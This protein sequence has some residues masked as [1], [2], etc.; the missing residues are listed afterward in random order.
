[1]AFSTFL[2][3]LVTFL[4][5]SY[6]FMTLRLHFKGNF[7][8]LFL[9]A[10]DFPLLSWFGSLHDATKPK[11]TNLSQIAQKSENRPL[12]TGITF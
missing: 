7:I 10:R 12:S 3:I 4:S 5:N 9:L 2:P 6:H 1:M 11:K 8:I